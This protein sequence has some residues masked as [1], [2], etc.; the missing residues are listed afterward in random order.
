MCVFLKKIIFHVPIPKGLKNIHM[1]WSLLSI[2]NDTA[3]V[4]TMTTK[5][6]CS[7]YVIMY[8]RMNKT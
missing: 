8:Y 2:H 4:V 7:S 1:N 6:L 3:V 5:K